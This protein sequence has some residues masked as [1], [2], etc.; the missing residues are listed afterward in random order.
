VNSLPT[1]FISKTLRIS[2]FCL[3]EPRALEPIDRSCLR[4]TFPQPETGDQ[5]CRFRERSPDHGPFP[6]DPHQML[7]GKQAEECAGCYEIRSVRFVRFIFH[8][9]SVA[10]QFTS[11][12]LP[13]SSE[14][15]C[16]NRHEFGV[17]SEITNRTKMARPLSVS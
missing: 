10:I 17:M 7:R 3:D 6:I 13:P 9:V 16:S 11:Q 15:A 2:N 5:F 1:S 14:N 8:R 12:V 4:L